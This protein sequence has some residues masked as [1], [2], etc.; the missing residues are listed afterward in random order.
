LGKSE[1]EIQAMLDSGDS[2][3]KAELGMAIAEVL[4]IPITRYPQ[5]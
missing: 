2:L 3:E 5:S 4:D 1:E